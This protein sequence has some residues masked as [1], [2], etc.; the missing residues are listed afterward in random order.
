MTRQRLLDAARRVIGRLGYLDT[1]VNDIV[2]EAGVARGSFY[3]YFESKADLFHQLAAT[4]DEQIDRDVVSFERS[5]DDPIET[6]KQA[7]RRYLAVV[8][9]NAD[10]YELVNQVAAI[11]P[12]I[13][14]LRLESRKHHV[15]RVAATIRRWQAAGIA[16]ASIDAET[17]AVALVAMLSNAAYWH[18]V[19]GD[20]H[21]EQSLAA[22][23]DSIWIAACGLRHR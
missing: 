8:R 7:N 9:A 21:D 18:Y 5:T 17:T 13:A 23:L 16:A 1:T 2:V 14:A 15:R 12:A 4:I 10:L 11:D 22:T 6:L 19:G 3:S 20:P